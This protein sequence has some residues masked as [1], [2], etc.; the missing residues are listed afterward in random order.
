M[1]PDQRVVSRWDRAR[2]RLRAGRWG[3]LVVVAGLLW[4]GLEAWGTLDFLGTRW[5]NLS[6]GLREW[7]TPGTLQ[8]VLVLVGVAWVVVAL[9]LPAKP[10]RAELVK[11]RDEARLEAQQLRG[12]LDVAKQQIKEL[13]PPEKAF[14][15][16]RPYCWELTRYFLE[17]YDKLDAPNEMHLDYSLRG[18][19]CPECGRNLRIDT[20]GS[21]YSIAA[22][23]PCGFDYGGDRSLVALRN[24]QREIYKEAQRLKRHGKACPLVSVL[25]HR[26]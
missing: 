8:V 4:R 5:I 3:G 11:Q 23:C 6:P 15:E 10:K 14:F 21:L 9:Y 2:S 24:M 7:L 20:Q 1:V 22:G 25:N 13:T 12:E 19:F 16:Y 26:R 18:P 17:N